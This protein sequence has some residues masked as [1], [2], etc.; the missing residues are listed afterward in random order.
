M[1]TSPTAIPSLLGSMDPAGSVPIPNPA[2]SNS[3]APWRAPDRPQIWK[4][5]GISAVSPPTSLM[6]MLLQASETPRK[7]SSSH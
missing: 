7:S 1:S 5:P 2:M 6:P 3:A 4:R